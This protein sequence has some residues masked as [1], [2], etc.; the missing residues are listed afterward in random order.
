MGVMIPSPSS[1][2]PGWIPGVAAGWDPR[3]P[4]VVNAEF[5]DV[6]LGARIC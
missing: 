6:Y 5:D 4:D 3:Y 1:A 2:M